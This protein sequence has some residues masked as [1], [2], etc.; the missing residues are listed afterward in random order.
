MVKFSLQEAILDI[1]FH[2][3][4]RAFV[5]PF[6]TMRLY[7]LPKFTM[8]CLPLPVL[9]HWRSIQ[10]NQRLIFQDSSRDNLSRWPDAMPREE[11]PTSQ[12]LLDAL[13]VVQLG[14]SRT[15]IIS[16]QHSWLLAAAAKQSNDFYLKNL[17]RELSALL[18]VLWQLWTSSQEQ[19]FMYFR[20]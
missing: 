8:S 20:P 16:H 12:S 10:A 3:F 18:V 4:A 19:N 9:K 14:W 15:P 11:N 17:W 5:P 7:F 6:T 2:Q 1:F 13:F